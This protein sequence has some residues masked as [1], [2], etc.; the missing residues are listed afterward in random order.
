MRIFTKSQIVSVRRSV[1][2][3]D[4]IDPRS[5]LLLK[6]MLHSMKISVQKPSFFVFY[7]VKH[8]LSQELISNPFLS[9]KKV[10]TSWDMHEDVF[11]LETLMIGRLIATVYRQSDASEQNMQKT[12]TLV[13]PGLPCS[14]EH[15][16][17]LS[18]FSHYSS[19]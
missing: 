4:I 13:P 8:N 11:L 18:C 7:S 9:C 15:L 3:Y 14:N 17:F 5:S 19:L 12:A 10:D 6:P 1:L 16:S 2:R